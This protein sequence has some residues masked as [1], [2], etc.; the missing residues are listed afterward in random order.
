MDSDDYIPD[1][2]DEMFVALFALSIIWI[3]EIVVIGM[4]ASQIARK[5][6]HEE[7]CQKLKFDMVI[8]HK[9]AIVCYSPERGILDL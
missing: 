9:Y 5:H 8:E 2:S 6:V 7:I 3:L 4:I 1:K